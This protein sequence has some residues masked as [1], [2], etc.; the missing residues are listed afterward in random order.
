MTT[1]SETE[2]QLPANHNHKAKGLPWAS[3]PGRPPAESGHE[4]GPRENQP[5][6]HPADPQSQEEENERNTIAL[7]H[8][9]WGNLFAAVN[10]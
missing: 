4:T 2:A 5:R 8:W 3:Q 7:S 6:K 10:N 9:S 1:G